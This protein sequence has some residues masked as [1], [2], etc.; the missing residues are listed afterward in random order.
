MISRISS[1]SHKGTTIWSDIY[2]TLE[3]WAKE[4]LDKRSGK[5]LCPESDEKLDIFITFVHF[6]DSLTQNESVIEDTRS[7]I[8]TYL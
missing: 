7:F 1:N 6:Y 2:G 4:N 3:V 5:T 8:K